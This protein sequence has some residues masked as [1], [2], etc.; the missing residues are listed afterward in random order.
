[1]EASPQIERR[2]TLSPGYVTH[3]SMPHP[4]I[5]NPHLSMPIQSAWGD[6]LLEPLAEKETSKVP[7][8]VPP[9][10]AP[11]LPQPTMV[12]QVRKLDIRCCCAAARLT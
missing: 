11:P 4:F 10:L 1:M 8:V 9:C 2:G 3:R 12:R 5:P 6:R 7:P